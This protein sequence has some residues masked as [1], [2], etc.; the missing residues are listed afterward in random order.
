V[1]GTTLPAAARWLGLTTPQRSGGR[2]T[3][4]AVITGD[5][6]HGLREITIAAG[7]PAT[8]QS[9]VSLGL[10]AGVL[11]VLLYRQGEIVVPQGGTVFEEGDRVLLLAEDE[12]FATARGLLVGGGT[13]DAH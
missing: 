4:D 11:V 6:G 8:G 9:L 1:Q 10:P 12:P 2:Y 13:P 5:E 3:F 7:A